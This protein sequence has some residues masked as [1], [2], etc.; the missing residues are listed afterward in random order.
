MRSNQLCVGDKVMWLRNYA[1]VY[2]I[3][4]LRFDLERCVY[5]CNVHGHEQWVTPDELQPYTPPKT[6]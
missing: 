5:I 2:E 4:A 1:D 6:E 3:I